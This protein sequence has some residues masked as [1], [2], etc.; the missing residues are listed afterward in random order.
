M[1]RRRTQS[2][3]RPMIRPRPLPEVG[4]S[5]IGG[6]G[7]PPGRGES[8][9]MGSA[10]WAMIVDHGRWGGRR[11][12]GMSGLSRAAGVG[13][14]ILSLRCKKIEMSFIDQAVASP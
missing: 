14:Q 8:H 4:V 10:G 13:V 11:S 5:S 2:L 6:N 12:M 1:G 9:A 3:L 7:R